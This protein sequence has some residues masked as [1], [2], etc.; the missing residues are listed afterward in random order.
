MCK[1][2]EQYRKESIILN[3]TVTDL[4]AAIVKLDEDSSIQIKEAQVQLSTVQQ[5]QE[6]T[7][8]QLSD[9]ESLLTTYVMDTQTDSGAQRTIHYSFSF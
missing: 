7:K 9:M 2:I 1:E 8:N 6:C 4:E 5:E 3:N